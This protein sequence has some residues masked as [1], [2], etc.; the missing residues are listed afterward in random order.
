[1]YFTDYKYNNFI[2]NKKTRQRRNT[3]GGLTNHK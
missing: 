2:L 1:M 3:A